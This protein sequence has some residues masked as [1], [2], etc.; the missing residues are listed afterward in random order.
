M[1]ATGG[2]M[3]MAIGVNLLGLMKIRIMNML[4]GLVYR[5]R[6]CKIV[7]INLRAGFVHV[8]APFHKAFPKLCEYGD[9]FCH[10]YKYCALRPP[11]L[12]KC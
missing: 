11:L 9:I 3:L 8:R 4:P 6:A 10:L 12:E 1:S 2:L 7:F 5:G